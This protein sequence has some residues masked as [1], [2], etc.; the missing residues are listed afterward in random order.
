LIYSLA[1]CDLQRLPVSPSSLPGFS[2][3]RFLDLAGL[4]GF[5]AHQV[6][7][8]HRNYFP[9]LGRVK[10]HVAKSQNVSRQEHC[11]RR[12]EFYTPTRQRRLSLSNSSGRARPSE[13]CHLE[14][15]RNRALKIPC[16]T[17][18]S[19]SLGK[20]CPLE[21]CGDA[22]VGGR[23][24]SSYGFSFWPGILFCTRLQASRSKSQK[25][26]ALAISDC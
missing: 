2:V 10:L 3:P 14:D 4:T 22:R 19:I 26:C 16:G 13:K 11:I 8:A 5:A 18:C 17:E 24:Q 6:L 1:A 25:P 12:Q 9:W 21:S 7:A 20:I 15:L 23:N